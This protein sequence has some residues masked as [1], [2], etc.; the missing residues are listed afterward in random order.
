MWASADV[1]VTAR[2]ARSGC[3]WLTAPGVAAPARL[4]RCVAGLSAALE[5]AG[6]ELPELDEHGGLGLLAERAALLGLEP[7]GR[8][9][10]GTATRLVETDDG[11]IAASLARATDVESVPAWLEVA[12]EGDVWSNVERA[13]RDRPSADVVERA[14]LLGLPCATV[15]EQSDPRPVLVAPHGSAAPRPLRG[16]LVVNLAALWAGP[17]AADLLARLGA[18]VVTVESTTRPDGARAHPAFF[19]SL[20][21]RCSSVAL[22]LSTAPGQDALRSLLAVADVVIEGSRPRA[23]EAM[24]IDAAELLRSGPRVWVSI[25]AHGRSRPWRERVGFGDDAAAG[26]GLVGHDHSGPTFLA[27][28]IGDPL[29]GLTTAASVAELLARGGRWLA[30]IAISRVAASMDSGERLPPRPQDDVRPPRPRQ[31]PGAWIELGRDTHSVLQDL[32][33][34]LP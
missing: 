15:G 27:D 28:A 29:S 21:G 32:G 30:D 13:V 6:C 31:D 14:A 16:A 9:S 24:S 26:G 1:D 7:G 23:L 33:I 19:A 3:Q 20:H 11:W 18:R 25:T 2:W 22:P 4:V 8:I 5:S 12:P 10:C 34:T 17:L